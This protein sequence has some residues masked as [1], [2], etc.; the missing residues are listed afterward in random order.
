MSIMSSELSKFTRGWALILAGILS[1]L[2]GDILF[3]LDYQGYSG[4]SIIDILW[5]VCY[6]L[7]AYALWHLR[8]SSAEVIHDVMSAEKARRR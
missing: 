6:L 5:W 7:W 3:A 2:A 1:S 8:K 4:G